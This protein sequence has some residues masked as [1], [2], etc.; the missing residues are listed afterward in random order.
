MR[1][2]KDGQDN[3]QT[4]YGEHI[5]C[6]IQCTREQKNIVTCTAVKAAMTSISSFVYVLLFLELLA[7]STCVV[8]VLQSHP[9]N[10]LK[11]YASA[12]EFEASDGAKLL[13]KIYSFLFP[14]F[15]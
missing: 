7:G 10:T 12:A 1:I 2:S 6:L 14:S 15:F 3:G 4:S 11:D 13:G 9:R 5:D 8:H